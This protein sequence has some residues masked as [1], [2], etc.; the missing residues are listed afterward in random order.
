[1]VTKETPAALLKGCT[2]GCTFSS[3]V[4]H[5]EATR[6][7]PDSSWLNL[8][9]LLFA[10]ERHHQVLFVTDSRKLELWDLTPVKRLILLKA[11]NLQLSVTNQRLTVS[12][13]AADLTHTCRSPPHACRWRQLDGATRTAAGSS[14]DPAELQRHQTHALIRGQRRP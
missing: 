8:V 1:M 4:I 5:M 6:V 9:Q 3:K 12:R 11:S 7:Q 13:A 10:G 2:C 14:C